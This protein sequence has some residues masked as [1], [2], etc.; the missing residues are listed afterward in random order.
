MESTILLHLRYRDERQPRI[1]TCEVFITGQF[2]KCVFTISVPIFHSFPFMLSFEMKS[3]IQKEEKMQRIHAKISM[4]DKQ[5]LT[6]NNSFD[7]IVEDLVNNKNIHITN[8]N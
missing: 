5:T 1:F 6:W 8:T 7:A 2:D 4:I 3:V